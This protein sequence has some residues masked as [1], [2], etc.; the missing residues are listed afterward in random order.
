[1][2]KMPMKCTRL[3]F[4]VLI[5]GFIFDFVYV[6]KVDNRT[7]EIERL[8]RQLDGGRSHDVVTLEGTLRNNEKVI[9]HQNIQVIQLR[10]DNFLASLKTD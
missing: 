10:R 4:P 2:K 7:S 1:M 9:S 5:D 6:L 8:N 3:S